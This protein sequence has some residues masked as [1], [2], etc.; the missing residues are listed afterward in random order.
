MRNSK[1]LLSVILLACGAGCRAGDAENLNT[2]LHAGVIDWRASGTEAESGPYKEAGFEE[3]GFLVSPRPYGDFRLSVEFW[4][5]D[6]TN[7]GILVRCTD[8]G[9]ITLENCYEINIWDNHPNPDARTG[10]IVMQAK[11]AAHV[12]TVGRWNTCVIEAIGGDVSAV[13]N[14]QPTAQ[15]SGAALL[16]GHIALQHA[17]GGRVRF[18][19]LKIEPL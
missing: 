9:S 11:P 4:I 14:G 16:S 13:F 12:E 10:A 15:L 3:M 7:S 8:P 1:L 17:G 6:D 5:D 18:R 19:N 2:W